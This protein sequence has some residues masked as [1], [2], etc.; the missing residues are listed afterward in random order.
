LK[1]TAEGLILRGW[2]MAREGHLQEGTAQ[3][4]QGLAAWQAMGAGLLQPY[5]LAL[6]AET[7]WW[8]GQYDAGL[9]TV[10]EA[11]AAAVHN[12]EPWWEPHLYWLKGELLLAQ[13]GIH[14]PPAAEACFHQA[15][16]S[17]R[18]Q[19]T[20]WLELRTAIS[21]SRLWQQQGKRAEARALLA[22]IY[23]WFTEGFATVEL[24]DAKAL[25]DQWK[26]WS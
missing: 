14:P 15:L 22:P 8:A 12:Q 13:H 24:Q 6:L 3:L 10:A 5:W 16:A 9:H 19:Q 20:K 2:T 4:R 1:D 25:L 23:A 26:G 17:A 18:H 21:L 7:Q 11:L